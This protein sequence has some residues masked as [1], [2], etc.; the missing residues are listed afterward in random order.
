MCDPVKAL[1]AKCWKDQELDL[2]PGRHHFDELLTIR[3]V[4]TAEKQA[5]QLVAPTTSIPM[6]TVI[7]LFWQRCGVTRDHA[8]TA[9]RESL[10]EAMQEGVDKEEKIK[11]HIKDCE[12]T[13]QAVKEQL[14]SRLPKVP[15]SGRLSTKDLRVEVLPVTEEQEALVPAA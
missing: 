10:I 5:D 7:A 4:G 15:R 2:E 13:I 14:I 11:S 6:L 1:I 9:L 8:M 3:V 12:A